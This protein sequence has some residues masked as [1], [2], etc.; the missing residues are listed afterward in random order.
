VRQIAQ[1]YSLPD[2]THPR[3]WIRLLIFGADIVSICQKFKNSISRDIRNAADGVNSYAFTKHGKD[4]I[5]FL[6]RQSVHGS[7]SSNNSNDDLEQV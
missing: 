4:L 5:A 2:D 3:N 7:A 1:S 6:V